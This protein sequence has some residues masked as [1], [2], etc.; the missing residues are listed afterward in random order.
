MALGI[1]VLLSFVLSDRVAN[2]QQL[3]LQRPWLALPFL[4]VLTL[5]LDGG[6]LISSLYIL[7]KRKFSLFFAISS[8]EVL[9]EFLR[10]FLYREGHR[11]NSCE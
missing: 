8:S 1:I 9:R 3:F 6:M 7:K 2:F 4:V 10:A 11:Y 5:A